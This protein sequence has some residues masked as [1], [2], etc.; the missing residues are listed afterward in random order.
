MLRNKGLTWKHRCTNNSNVKPLAGRDATF[1]CETSQYCLSRRPSIQNL[2]I[3]T[4]RVLI[5]NDTSV[6]A[7]VTHSD[8]LSEFVV[9]TELPTLLA[10]LG[11]V[12][13]L[14]G[15]ARWLCLLG[16]NI[17]RCNMCVAPTGSPFA[18]LSGIGVKRTS[19]QRASPW[20]M[21]SHRF[22]ESDTTRAAFV[23][24][25]SLLVQTL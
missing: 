15:K 7:E 13:A 21:H 10:R 1:K 20:G 6:S 8:Q 5:C 11:K 25:L 17:C 24:W 4:A 16:T 2:Q 22:P 19:N 9:D 14:G 12:R 23:R 18:M 3:S